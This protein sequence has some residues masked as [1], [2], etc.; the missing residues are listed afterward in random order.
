[1]AMAPGALGIAAGVPAAY[2]LL[3]GSASGDHYTGLVALAAGAA[4]LL[5]IPVTLWKARRT[6]RSRRRRYV[7][8]AGTIVA[9]PVVGAVLVWVI[10]FPL[11][12]SYGYTHTG[13]TAVAP[14]LRVPYESVTVT[15]SDSLELTA[16]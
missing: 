12:F 15:T 3:D 7:G 14:D 2:Y 11:G 1:M 5:T 6:G 4:I 9:A 10:V 13:R 16:S 8:R